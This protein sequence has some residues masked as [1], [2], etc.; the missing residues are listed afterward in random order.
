MYNTT[1]LKFLVF[2]WVYI[3]LNNSE[4]RK[5][6]I[7]FLFITPNFGEFYGSPCSYWNSV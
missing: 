2:N 5:L 1:I 3:L 4:K 7:V 6:Q